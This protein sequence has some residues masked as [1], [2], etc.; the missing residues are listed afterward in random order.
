MQ[1]EVDS[2]SGPQAS[3]QGH[4]PATHLLMILRNMTGFLLPFIWSLGGMVPSTRVHV[5]TCTKISQYSL[6]NIT[7]KDANR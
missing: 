7:L 2:D 4:G 5:T 6:W 1:E 3:R